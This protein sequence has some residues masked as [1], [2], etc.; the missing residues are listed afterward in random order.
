MMGSEQVWRRWRLAP[1]LRLR[2]RRDPV[3]TGQLR[4]GV[5]STTVS[6]GRSV[7]D[8]SWVV[9]TGST[10]SS[11]LFG[12]KYLSSQWQLRIV[13][14]PVVECE[15]TGHPAH[16]LLL[17]ADGYGENVL[18]VHSEHWEAWVR[19]H[20]PAA[21]TLQSLWD[22]DASTGEAVPGW[23]AVHVDV[24]PSANVPGWHWRTTISLPWYWLKPC[25]GGREALMRFWSSTDIFRVAFWPMINVSITIWE[26]VFCG[27]SKMGSIV[28]S[29]VCHLMRIAT[30]EAMISLYT[31]RILTDSK[32]KRPPPATA[33]GMMTWVAESTPEYQVANAPPKSAAPP[34]A[35]TAMYVIML[36]EDPVL[37]VGIA[38]GSGQNVAMGSVG[39]SQR[40]QD[41]FPGSV[42]YE[43]LKHGSQPKR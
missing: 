17:I 38:G 27:A 36:L 18:A 40:R 15:W 43:L 16:V 30:V 22:S 1:S 12:R 28:I 3:V 29:N 26:L 13:S 8:V 2:R 31:Y 32:L 25:A 7:H 34:P 37:A 5:S 33:V 20:A 14:V 4:W 39:W 42:L 21:H 9:L 23:H 35:P 11:R 41:P 24:P 19:A 10:G 6:V